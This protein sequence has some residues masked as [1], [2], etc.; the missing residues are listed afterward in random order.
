MVKGGETG[1]E[2]GK[3]MARKKGRKPRPAEKRKPS[4]RR[5]EGG[6]LRSAHGR[7]V[8]Q[9]MQIKGRLGVKAGKSRF[10][11]ISETRTG[12]TLTNRNAGGIQAKKKESD[13]RP[14]RKQKLFVS[15]VGGGRKR[16][17]S[18]EGK[19]GT[20]GKIAQKNSEQGQV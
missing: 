11:F 7:A 8:V 15:G 9:P 19:K 20:R 14:W 17:K 1:G 6:R 5:G 18:R 10:Q 4:A 3:E 13:E 16:G 2:S 12:K